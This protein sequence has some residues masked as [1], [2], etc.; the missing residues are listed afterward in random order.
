MKDKDYETSQSTTSH[1]KGSYWSWRCT[2][3]PLARD[4]CFPTKEP[5]EPK[6]H[7]FFCWC[8]Y[9]TWEFDL[10]LLTGLTELKAQISWTDSVTVS[11][12][13]ILPHQPSSWPLCCVY[14]GGGTKV[15]NV[16]KVVLVWE[17]EF[18]SFFFRSSAIVVYNDLA[19]WSTWRY[20]CAIVCC[21]G[22][23]TV[24]LLSQCLLTSCSH[25]CIWENCCARYLVHEEN[26]TIP[27]CKIS[28]LNF[29]VSSPPHLMGTC[30]H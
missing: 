25:H 13:G 5:K 10:I 30:S 26:E 24:F 15:W 28:P 4:P 12:Q 14:I 17:A 8:R 16:W 7:E 18:A 3:G 1:V 20:F 27:L 21:V 9:Y 11:S 2:A 6:F 19:D 29:E 22:F 23:A